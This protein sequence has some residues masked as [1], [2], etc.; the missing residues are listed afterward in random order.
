M[1][2]ETSSSLAIVS[3]CFARCDFAASTPWLM[4]EAWWT[5]AYTAAAVPAPLVSPKACK[6]TASMV[7]L[8]AGKLRRT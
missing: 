4:P 6:L 3:P 2:A 8:K 1:C 7:S 5:T